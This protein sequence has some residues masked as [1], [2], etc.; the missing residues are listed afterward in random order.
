M[1]KKYTVDYCHG[2]TG[3]GWSK[4]FDRLDEFEDFIN[5]CRRDYGAKVRVW[6]NTLQKVIFQK[7]CSWN[8]SV[9]MLQDISRDMRTTDRKAKRHTA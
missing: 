8:P 6:D 1:V 9:D 5:D 4:E 7:G 3:Y 2:N